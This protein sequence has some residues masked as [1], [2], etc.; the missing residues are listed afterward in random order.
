MSYL[1]PEEVYGF[2]S[3]KLEGVNGKIDGKPIVTE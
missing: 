2:A 3:A 1:N